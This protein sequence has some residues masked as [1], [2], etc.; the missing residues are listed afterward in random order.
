MNSLSKPSRLI[1]RAS[2]NTCSVFLPVLLRVV[3]VFGNYAP[4]FEL[5]SADTARPTTVAALYRENEGGTFEGAIERV[6]GR[7][8]EAT[9]FVPLNSA[10]RSTAIA[11]TYAP[12]LDL[13]VFIASNTWANLSP[14]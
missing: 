5:V 9:P 13:F 3:D 12:L 11:G 10:Q 4:P 7:A 8:Y 1:V 2:R 14:W 6:I